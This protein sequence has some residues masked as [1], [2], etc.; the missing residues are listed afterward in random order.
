[1]LSRIKL[2]NH[3]IRAAVLS[4]DDVRLSID[5]LKA[6]SRQLPTQEEVARL[7]DFG[8]LSKLAKADQYF[9]SV[10]CAEPQVRRSSAIRL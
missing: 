7:R 1:M 3:D 5:D 4:L 6:M 2:S 9:G 8:D 10:S